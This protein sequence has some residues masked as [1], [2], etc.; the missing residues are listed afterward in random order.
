MTNTNN[1]NIL[2]IGNEENDENG[3]SLYP[4]EYCFTVSNQNKSDFGGGKNWWCIS[5]W[6]D[7][8]EFLGDEKFSFVHID[9]GSDLWLLDKDQEL[10][11]LRHNIGKSDFMLN[12]MNN[13]YKEFL[14]EK[15][16]KIEKNRCVD[17]YIL[18]TINKS[19]KKKLADY[20]TSVFN[21][22]MEVLVKHLD[23]DTGIF[24]LR[25]TEKGQI[26]CDNKINFF[27]NIYSYL[28]EIGYRMSNIDEIIKIKI[29]YNQDIF[30][31]PLRIFNT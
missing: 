18:F 6:E 21:K 28:Y 24:L 11:N 17:M 16:I 5:F 22:M 10:S 20:C 23:K 25:C 9:I 14:S 26:Y 2:I 30:V 12:V 1:K 13:L 31:N 4:K 7:L 19:L 29:K 8:D 3:V 15:N 27:K